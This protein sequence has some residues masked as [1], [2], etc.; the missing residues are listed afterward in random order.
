MRNIA[1]S[2]AKDRLSELVAAAE[3][4]EEIV[5]TRHGKPAAK[6]VAV[7]SKDERRARNRAALAELDALRSELRAKGRRASPAEWKQWRDEG[8]P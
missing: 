1:L 3:G 4:G 8:R 6:L 7:I 2:V 5:I